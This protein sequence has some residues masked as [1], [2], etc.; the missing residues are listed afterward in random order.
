MR[1][2]SSR[3]IKNCGI[4]LDL[5]QSYSSVCV[6]SYSSHMKYLVIKILETDASFVPFSMAS[7]NMAV[8]SIHIE[9]KW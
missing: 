9:V 6:S 1:S 2:L 4:E 5:V 8:V 3:H 7:P